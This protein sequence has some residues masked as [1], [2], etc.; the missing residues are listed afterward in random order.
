MKYSVSDRMDIG[1][2]SS[3]AIFSCATASIVFVAEVATLLYREC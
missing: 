2:A 3:I 1:S